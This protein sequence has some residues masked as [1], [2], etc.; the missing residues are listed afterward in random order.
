MTMMTTLLAHP[1][2]WQ[3]GA[4]DAPAFWP[5]FP[6][7]F[8]LFW[9]A[10]FAGAFYL[11]RRRINAGAAATAAENDPLAQARATLADRFARGDIDE[12]EYHSRL[13]ALR[14]GA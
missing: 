11:I 8:G 6:I 2:P 7:T 3:D 14:Y 9:L 1:G 4:H 12:D 13:S 10:V 5:V